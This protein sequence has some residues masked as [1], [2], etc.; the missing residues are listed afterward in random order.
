[1]RSTLIGLL[2][3]AGAALSLAGH[4]AAADRVPSEI[5]IKSGAQLAGRPPV[6]NM[7]TPDAPW[8][9]VAA[10]VKAAEFPPGNIER[11]KDEDLQAAFREMKRRSIALALGT[12]LLARSVRCQATNEAM[13]SA[14]ELEQLLLKIRRNGGDLRYIAMDEP[15]SFGHRDDSGCHQSAAELA[16]NVA[17]GV[18]IARG[19][20]RNVEVGD[21]EVVDASRPRTQDLA[22]WADAYRAAT[23]EKLAFMQ[24]DI[25]WSE[26]AMRNL[27]PLSAALRARGIP[28]AIIYNAD[29]STKTDESWERNAESHIA[30]IEGAIGI[31]PDIAVFDSWTANP[32][33]PLPETAPGTLTNLALRYL[34]PATALSLTRQG[35]TVTGRLT[36]AEG[37]PVAGA[38]ITVTA[39]DAG[40]RTE[41]TIRSVS[42]MA[43]Q[44][45]AN[46]LIGIR[47]DSEG[48]CVCDGVAGA[49]IGGI[50]YEEKG[51]GRRQTV[52]PVNLPIE[53]APASFRTLTLT[54]GQEFNPNL[55]QFAVTA[56]APYTFAA[57]I[58]ATASAERAGYAAL[59]FADAK[60]KGLKRDF[61]WFGP[62]RRDLNAPPTNPDGRFT[63]TLPEPTALGRPEI[64]AAFAGNDHFRPALAIAEPQAA[65]AAPMPALAQALSA[66]PSSAPRST[67]IMLAP[68]RSDFAPIIEGSAPQAPWNDVAGRVNVISVTEGDVRALPD[69]ALARLVQDLDRRHI[70]LGLG[71]LP[72][73][74]FHELP[75][76]GGVEG[77]SDPGSA[78][79]TV[80]KLMKAGASVSLIAMD[81]PLW[82]G[83][84]YT[85]KNACRSSIE[86]VAERTAVIV[87]IY[88]AAFPNVIVGDTEPFPAVSSQPNWTADFVGWTAAF[89][90]ATGTPLAFLHLDFNW[91]D[92][93]L[94]TGSAHDGSNASA[95]AALAREVSMVARR[96]GLEVGMIYWGGGGSDSQWM[97][98]AR[99]HI[100]EVEA[101]GIEPDQVI[102]VSWNPYPARTF[103]ATDPAA[104]ASLIPYYF[105]H[106]H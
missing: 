41:P 28:L 82:F 51:T 66:S 95:V 52:S 81:E 77:Y 47:V 20:F 35:S 9:M 45:A 83:H 104:L 7:W 53:G 56:G 68:R 32:S 8:P 50:H 39:V 79:Q 48:A 24:T 101:V 13:G 93:R 80:A 98:Q 54:P 46:A 26:L 71:I 99:L 17:Q 88:T 57:P 25:N 87:K 16:A 1:M 100:R 60:G 21:I 59:I 29:A 67:L 58:A 84:Y 37:R 31:H 40:A 106:H 12:G 19:I 70:A 103:P 78:N 61:L 97:D 105:Q 42:G 96:N 74:W 86:N 65:D 102:F 72:T 62:S 89:R 94:N 55:R 2:A 91:G 11:A 15:Y 92:Q 90:K 38:S 64:R 14:G 10:H 85:G 63:L 4:A 23:G 6:D 3:L 34:K 30:E 36:D 69:E 43:P 49:V 44:G 27:T 5:W 18:A 75:C 22:S 73:N 76:G 33:H